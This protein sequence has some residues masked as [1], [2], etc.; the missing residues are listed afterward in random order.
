MFE[1]TLFA[2]YSSSEMDIFVDGMD[3]TVTRITRYP[4]MEPS[5]AV[6][7]CDCDDGYRCRKIGLANRSRLQRP[8]NNVGMCALGVFGL[9]L[10]NKANAGRVDEI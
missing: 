8:C 4:L 7:S 2:I 5:S 3:L 10:C 1:D 9:P 6:K